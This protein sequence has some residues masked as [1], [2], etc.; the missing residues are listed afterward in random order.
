[1]PEN[2]HYFFLIFLVPV[3]FLS[4]YLPA[5]S[6]E[7]QNSNDQETEWVSEFYEENEQCFKCH[8]EAKYSLYDE[9]SERE[10]HKLMCESRVINRDKYYISNHKSFSCLDCHDGGYQD[11]PHPVELRTEEHY[12]C[13]DCHGYDENYA[14]YH[15]E[16]IEEEYVQSIH[17]ELEEEGFN[18]WKCHN[19]HTYHISIRNTTNL[20]ETI[21]Y[22]NNICLDC[23]SNFNRF[24]LLTE[25][26]EINIIERH[27]W[28]PNQA[29]HFGNVRCIECH[30]QVNDSILV[31]HLLLPIEQAVQ[32]CV[33]C[34]SRD[35]RLLT[36]LY[37]F[38]AKK[39]RT[40]AGFW[41]G[42]VLKESYV[43]G[44]N[45]NLYLNIISITIFFLTIAGILAHLF[46][47][48]KAK[49]NQTNS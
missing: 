40:R 39:Q 19:P 5:V 3:L 9:F 22:D 25:R 10:V 34:H 7:D 32:R 17:A 18:C 36:T 47:R 2:K 46:F 38:E 29:L 43:I 14:Q 45:R 30:T 23:H 24:Q 48:M 13:L 27:D 31:A 21:A 37:K 44:A 26:D 16:E 11:F 33:E 8:G 35:S 6:Q 28:L 12:A 42:A 41:N 20:H 49:S 15:F 1:M 4:G